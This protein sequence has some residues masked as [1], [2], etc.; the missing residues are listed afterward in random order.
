MLAIKVIL[1]IF[2]Y[3][4]YYYIDISNEKHNI[5]FFS[6][7]MTVQGG[8]PCRTAFPYIYAPQQKLRGGRPGTAAVA[9]QVGLGNGPLAPQLVVI[10]QSFLAWRIE[11]LARLSI[12]CILVPISEPL[13]FIDSLT[14]IKPKY[15]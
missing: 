3:L 7:Q 14:S 13:S 8:V 12:F 10:F 1:R 2:L 15:I 11:L 6:G 4:S 5:S 9:G